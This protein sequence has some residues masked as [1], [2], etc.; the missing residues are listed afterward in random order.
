ML[1]QAY[2]RRILQRPTTPPTMCEVQKE[3]EDVEGKIYFQGDGRK[4]LVDFIHLSSQNAGEDLEH[5][6][7]VM[8]EGWGLGR[9]NLLV[10]VTGHE[11]SINSSG[12]S[13]VMKNFK[14]IIE[15]ISKIPATWFTTNGMRSG[16]G[17]H[18]GDVLGSGTSLDSGSHSSSAVC[19]GV[20]AWGNIKNRNKLCNIPSDPPDQSRIFPYKV[21]SVFASGPNGD[22]GEYLDPNHSHFVLFNEKIYYGDAMKFRA[23]LEMSLVDRYV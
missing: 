23:E 17:R 3:H 11:D 22:G 5:V 10:S 1:R 18:V 14:R 13:P 2:E 9:P 15:R 19:I 21:G 6:F 12:N 4:S 20:S 16:I 8:S 7:D